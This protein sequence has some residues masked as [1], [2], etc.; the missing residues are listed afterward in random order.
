MKFLEKDLEQIIFET[1]ERD[2]DERGIYVPG[3]RLR[4]LNIGNYGVADMVTFQRH[5][6]NK[7]L[8]IT[9]YELKKD[10]VGID[11]FLQAMRYCKGI[12][13]YLEHRDFK[14]F[15]YR[16]TYN[17]VLIGSGLE[18]G[19]SFIYLQD[20]YKNLEVFT[21]KYD[22]DGISFNQ[23]ENYHLIKSGF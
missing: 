1:S 6:Y 21:Y 18:M 7:E 13:H 4:Q 9:V 17:I 19:S 3:K 11:A 14:L 5:H 20:F 2:L 12:S 22:F 16:V 23:E 15:G 8:V 10:T